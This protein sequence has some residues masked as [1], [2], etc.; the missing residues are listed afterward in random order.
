MTGL[1]KVEIFSAGCPVCRETVDLVNE[2][3]CPSCEVTVFDMH[4]TEGAARAKELGVASVPAVAVNS[5][6]VAC[7]EGRGVSR[8][9]LVRAGV[10]KAL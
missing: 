9:E 3:S 6:L 1:R 4:S 10:G 8:D 2:L 7:C 5:K